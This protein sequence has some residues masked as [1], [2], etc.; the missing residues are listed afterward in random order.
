MLAFTCDI[1]WAPE[2]VIADTLNIF[3]ILG[4]KCTMFSTHHSLEL[5]K[6]NR[7]LFDRHSS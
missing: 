3:E 2:E 4:V 7:K 1:D 6:S 5:T